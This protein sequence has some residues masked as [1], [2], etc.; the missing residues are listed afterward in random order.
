MWWRIL[1]G[2]LAVAL[3]V[4]GGIFIFRAGFTQ[5]AISAGVED[6]GSLDFSD[7]PYAHGYRY[8]M[9]FHFFPFGSFLFGFLFLMLFFGF[10][11][12]ALCAPRW[13]LHGPR[14]KFRASMMEEW[15]A[16][17]HQRMGQ[18]QTPEDSSQEDAPI[19]EA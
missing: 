7:L 14:G 5:G 18:E 3:L 16:E 10:V 17:M 13:G 12:R 11:R 15:H 4:A 19:E 6:A 1:F 2:V 8:P 9:R